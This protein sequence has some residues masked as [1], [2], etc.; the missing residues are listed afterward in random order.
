MIFYNCEAAKLLYKT[1]A[2]VLRR[3]SGPDEARFAAYDAAGLPAKRL[4][5]SSGEYCSSTELDVKHWGLGQDFYCHA[6]SPIRRWS[7]CLNQLA[8]RRQI[9]CE[10]SQP[11]PQPV[12][13]LLNAR[14]KALKSYERDIHFMRAVLGGSKEV[15]GQIAEEGRIWVP[16]W[17]RIVKAATAGAPGTAVKVKFFCDA[18]KR[19]WKRRMVL[20]VVY[21]DLVQTI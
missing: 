5:M 13:N 9:L 15:E 19:N 6:S 1:D 8:I 16:A 12:I 7:D 3:H 11:I 10:E 17:G 21:F 14:S 20:N 18:T 4:A 2:G